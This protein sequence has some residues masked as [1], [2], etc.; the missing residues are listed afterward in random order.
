MQIYTGRELQDNQRVS[1]SPKGP[2]W[3]R[4]SQAERVM[5]CIVSRWD[6]KNLSQSEF[7]GEIA[8]QK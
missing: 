8:E 4:Y 6:E 5:E 1:L 3:A 2:W 7:L